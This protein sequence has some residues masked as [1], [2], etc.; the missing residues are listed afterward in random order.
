MK[1][2]YAYDDGK[3]HFENGEPIYI[4]KVQEKTEHH[5]HAHDFLEIAYVVSGSGIHTIGK[6]EYNV[7]KGDLFIINHDIPHEFRSSEDMSQ[8][9][10]YVYNCVFKPEFLDYRLV[11]TKDFRI[12]MESF[13]FRSLAS[14]EG[15]ASQE[16]NFVK[17]SDKNIEDL[18][19][20][21]FR[22]FTLK[23]AGYIEV[24]R[25]YVIELIV[26]IFRIYSKNNSVNGPL[27]VKRREMIDKAINFMKDNYAKDLKLE[28]ISTIA[29][30]SPGYF[31][32]LFK[33]STSMTISEY[34]QNLRIEEACTILKSSDLKV[35]DVAQEV[36]YR[37][38]KFFNQLFKKITGKTPGQYRKS[39]G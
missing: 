11:N 5:L 29:F 30:L 36:G 23:E 7:S 1:K 10:L 14:K 31:N 21:M 18:Y 39:L 17:S 32:R 4:N 25:A 38:I 34:L 6:D 3:R 2:L 13:L 22:E 16:V 12:I 33:E 9:R 20:K 28:D 35:I 15:L 27:E 26:T 8:P 24:M 19:E 37:D